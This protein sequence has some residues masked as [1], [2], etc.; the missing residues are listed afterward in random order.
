MT[1]HNTKQEK[2]KGSSSKTP[3]ELEQEQKQ[4]RE[5]SP[6]QKEQKAAEEEFNR[7]RAAEIATGERLARSGGRTY[8]D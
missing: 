1:H 2:P 5:L 7:K 6:E 8:G 4:K 3:E